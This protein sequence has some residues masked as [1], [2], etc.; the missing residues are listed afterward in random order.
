MSDD[1]EPDPYDDTDHVR[2]PRCDGW[3]HI[4]CHCGGDLCVCDNYGEAYCPL[5]HGEGDVSK[6]TEQAYRKRQADN[7]AAWQKAMGNEE[8]HDA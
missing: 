6:A 3:G 8:A 7:W 5:C 2:C 4:D 1:Y